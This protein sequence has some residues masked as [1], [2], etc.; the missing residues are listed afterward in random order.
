MTNNVSL[1][2]VLF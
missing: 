1:P 2:S